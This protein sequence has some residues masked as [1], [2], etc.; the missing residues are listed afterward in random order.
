MTC[1][2]N[3]Q[4]RRPCVTCDL[5]KSIE[6]MFA[7][8]GMIFFFSQYWTISWLFH[9]L[10][11]QLLGVFFFFN[12]KKRTWKGIQIPSWKTH[13]PSCPPPL[14]NS[15]RIQRLANCSPRHEHHICYWD[16]GKTVESSL[17]ACQASESRFLL[18]RLSING[19]MASA[20]L[21]GRFSSPNTG[22]YHK[23][24]VHWAEPF[25][26]P[27]KPFLEGGE[28]AGQTKNSGGTGFI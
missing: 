25:V 27:L 4:V 23:F 21:A 24:M 28:R 5:N 12:L 17:A 1:R 6:Q 10:K 8:F 20:P 18:T 14:I 15:T 9:I 19:Q 2:A 3:T 11:S 16:A 7:W 13:I 26:G 22:R